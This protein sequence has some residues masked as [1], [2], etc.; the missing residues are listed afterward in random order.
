MA[1]STDDISYLLSLIKKDDP[2]PSEND[3]LD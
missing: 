1:S 3:S 2:S